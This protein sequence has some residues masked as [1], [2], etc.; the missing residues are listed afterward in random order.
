[1]SNKLQTRY[2]VLL[3]ND[4]MNSMEYVVEILMEVISG[5]TQPQA[6]NAMMEAHHN[7]KGLVV[8]CGL[9]QAEFY[10]KTLCNHGLNVT[11]EPDE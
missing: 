7:E 11:F 8:T 1:M 10:C 4:N 6:V 9:E 5:M 2:T 3:H